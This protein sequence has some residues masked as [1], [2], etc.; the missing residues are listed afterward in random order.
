[1]TKPVVIIGGRGEMG[2][3]FERFFKFEGYDVR[4]IDKGDEARLPNAV[5]GAGLVMVSVPIDQTVAV[6]ESLPKLD[7]DTLLVDI[8]S[9]KVE[10]MMAMLAKHTGPVVGLH[11]MFGPDV[12]E[13]TDQV[14]VVCHGR[15]DEGAT[16]LLDL[17]TK[18]QAK[19]HVA[20]AADH[21]RA[22][23]MVQAL[24]HFTTFAYGVHLKS[25]E[26]EITDLLAFSSPI[27]RLELAMV[28][29]LFAQDPKL[30]A[31]IIFRSPE[32]K[33]MI[34]RYIDT[35]KD[36]LHYLENDDKE[37]FIKTFL[38]VRDWMGEHAD[39]FLHETTHLLETTSGK[40]S[41]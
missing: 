5:K 19:L 36:V 15:D 11:P 26:A 9:T 37:G 31:D 25:E 32:H 1:M 6:I 23:V 12:T 27:Y 39:K 40:I 10:P 4:L 20:K 38:E 35:L 33:V 22:M 28:G 3:M 16:W 8:T 17:F 41:G 18:H 21:D 24:R 7:D 13:L 34:E 30:Y 2:L 14:I 29:R